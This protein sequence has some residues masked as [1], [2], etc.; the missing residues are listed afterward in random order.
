MS[1]TFYQRCGLLVPLRW[2]HAGGNLARPSHSR[3]RAVRPPIRSERLPRRPRQ[4]SDLPCLHISRARRD[5]F[6]PSIDRGANL[7]SP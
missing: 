3:Q 4:T 5:N 6:R 7:K 1:L 2:R